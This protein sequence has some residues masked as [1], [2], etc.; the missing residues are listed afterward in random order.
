[1]NKI[2]FFLLIF[3][4]GQPSFAGQIYLN[5]SFVN[6]EGVTEFEELSLDPETNEAYITTAIY[7]GSP[8]VQAKPLVS[9]EKYKFSFIYDG[10]KYVYEVNRVDGAYEAFEPSG[11]TGSLSGRGGYLGVREKN[12]YHS[13][14]CQKKLKKEVPKQLF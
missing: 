10:K 8:Q 1:M 12:V 7:M 11:M 6:S 3:F 5:C 14:K 13:G 9:S 2:L 4:V